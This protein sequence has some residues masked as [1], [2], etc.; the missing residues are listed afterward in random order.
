MSY[1]PMKLTQPANAGVTWGSGNVNVNTSQPAFYAYLSATVSNV[2]GDGTNYIIAFDTE[3]YDNSSSFTTG[4]SAGFTAPVTGVYQFDGN[5]NVS[6][7][8]GSMT[9]I[10]VQ[11]L[12]NFTNQWQLIRL[13]PANMLFSGSIVSMPFSLQLKL[14]AADF[15]DLR[16]IISGGTKVADL[17]KNAGWDN[18]YLAGHLVC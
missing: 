13:N 11:F 10:L 16:L 15:I 2:T 4:A 7:M 18:T 3:R 8:T 9:D 12:Q 5:I 1:Y 6:G 17:P 14:T